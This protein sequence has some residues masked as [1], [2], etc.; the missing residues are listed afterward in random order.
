MAA[1]VWPIKLPGSW[2]KL[3]DR[4]AVKNPR[5]AAQFAHLRA[6]TY[7]PELIVLE[8]QSEAIADA[9]KADPMLQSHLL[10]Y[11]VINFGFTGRVEV[12]RMAQ[13]HAR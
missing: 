2:R 4:V 6:V 9:F 12:R 13:R 8:P 10:R 1:T 5:Q 7:S 11:L 3:M